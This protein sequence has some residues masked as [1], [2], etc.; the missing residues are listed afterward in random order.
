MIAAFTNWRT[1]AMPWKRFVMVV[2]VCLLRS[3]NASAEECLDRLVFGHQD[4]E[5]RHSL[6]ESGSK[7]VVGSLGQSARQLLPLNPISYNGGSVSFVMH[8]DPKEQNYF[9]VK[10]WGSDSGEARGRLILYLDGQQIR[11][12]RSERQ[13]P[14]FP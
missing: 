9:T 13:A 5:Q 6:L 3:T 2:I 8:V 11:Y 4:S 10:L 14:H 12:P 7:I 1:A